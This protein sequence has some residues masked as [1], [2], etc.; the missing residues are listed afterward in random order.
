[1]TPREPPNLDLLAE[2]VTRYQEQQARKKR[3][4]KEVAV[5]AT[6]A[7]SGPAI[8]VAVAVALSQIVTAIWGGEPER[9]PSVAPIAEHDKAPHAHG[10]ELERLRSDVAACKA[11][12]E[13]LRLADIA[14]Q[15]TVQQLQHPRRRSRGP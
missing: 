11:G 12:M 6:K 8:A 4:T 1:M 5:R 15:A 2:A 14:I 13:S 3:T 7:A 9:K 10:G